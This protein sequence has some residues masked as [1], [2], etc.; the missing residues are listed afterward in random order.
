MK[1]KKVVII[2]GNRLNGDGSITEIQKQRLEL[3]LEIEKEF[4]PDYY[5]LSGGPANPIPNKSEAQAMYEYL[6]EKGIEKERLILEDKSYSTVENAK[7]SVPIA[8]KLNP[9][10]IIL[11]TSAYHLG[12]PIYKAMESFINELKDSDITLMTYS[13]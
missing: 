2:L 11:C 10:M 1:T 12:N 6:I 5:I 3:A 8:K 9:D 13:R 4:N 7:Y